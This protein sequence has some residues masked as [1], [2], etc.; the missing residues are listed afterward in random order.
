MTDNKQSKDDFIFFWKKEAQNGV[1]C[2]WKSSV[3]LD[4]DIKYHNCEQ[5]MMAQKA[6]LFIDEFP[7]ENQRILDRIMN[8]TSPKAIKRMGREIRGFKEKIWKKNR[9]EIVVKGNLLKFSQNESMK[10]KLLATGT[11]NL[12]EASPMDPIWGI[13]YTERNALDNMENWGS[14]LLGLALMDV[15]KQLR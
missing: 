13:G 2:Q 8:S 7:R 9:Y 15:R 12:V 10:K 3:F 14:N 11:K 6:L 1:Y 4:E 5:Y